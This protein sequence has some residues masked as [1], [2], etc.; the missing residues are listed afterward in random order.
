MDDS[1]N[2]RRVPSFIIYIIYGLI[3]FPIIFTLFRSLGN[4]KVCLLNGD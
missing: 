1:K 3:A 4:E 2:R